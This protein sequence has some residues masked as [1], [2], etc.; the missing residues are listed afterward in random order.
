[1]LRFRLRVVTEPRARPDTF[2][3]AWCYAARLPRGHNETDCFD[4]SFRRVGACSAGL[5]L[6]VDEARNG[7][8]HVLKTDWL[9]DPRGSGSRES[10]GLVRGRVQQGR[11]LSVDE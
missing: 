8:R 7:A 11:V 6:H 5:R 2:L 4:V 10:G 1:M 9:P 3:A